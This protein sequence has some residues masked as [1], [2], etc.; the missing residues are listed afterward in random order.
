MQ[1]PVWFPFEV[2]TLMGQRWTGSDN[3][4]GIIKLK[5]VCVF[6]LGSIKNVKNFFENLVNVS[7]HVAF[8]TYKIH[9]LPKNENNFKTGQ[10]HK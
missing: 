6:V 10:W 7:L 2:I 5:H 9:T 8:L 4:C 3:Q 1:N